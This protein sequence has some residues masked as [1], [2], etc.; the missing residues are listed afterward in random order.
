[1]VRHLL[2]IFVEGRHI[3]E[4]VL[5][6]V[7][8]F[9][10]LLL[11]ELVR[12]GFVGGLEPFHLIRR[13]LVQDGCSSLPVLAGSARPIIFT[14]VHEHLVAGVV[15]IHSLTL[16]RVR[17]TGLDAQLVLAR[18]V[19][20]VYRGWNLLLMACTGFLFVLLLVTR[21][22]VVLAGTVSRSFS[23]PFTPSSVAAPFSSPSSSVDA[24]VG[25]GFLC[26]FPSPAACACQR[27]VVLSRTRSTPLVTSLA[28]ACMFLWVKP[29]TAPITYS[30]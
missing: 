8:A 1:M 28:V 27:I 6:E 7:D 13:P 25:F 10:V 21:C 29:R 16:S 18:V 11:L 5:V 14:L 9:V 15:A 22:G 17:V 30:S 19:V 2:L 26:V 24:T 23:V 20:L 12:L 4:R 3:T